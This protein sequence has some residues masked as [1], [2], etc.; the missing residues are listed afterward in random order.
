MTRGGD[1][2]RRKAGGGLKHNAADVCSARTKI[3]PVERRGDPLVNSG[4]YL[5]VNSS[6]EDS[7]KCAP[8][9][10]KM[11]TYATNSSPSKNL[12]IS[13]VPKTPAEHVEV[14]LIRRGRRRRRRVRQLQRGCGHVGPGRRNRATAG[15]RPFIY[16]STGCP[17]LPRFRGFVRRLRQ[18]LPDRRPRETGVERPPDTPGCRTRSGPLRPKETRQRPLLQLQA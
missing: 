5:G 3:P 16:F 6:V 10:Q 11:L 17:D 15:L 4:E 12:A 13:E 2:P 8:S 1:S 7:Y 9:V 14:V 18:S